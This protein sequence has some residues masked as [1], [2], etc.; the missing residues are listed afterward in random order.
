MDENNFTD[1]QGSG[2]RYQ[3]TSNPDQ[4]YTYGSYDANAQNGSFYAGTDPGRRPGKLPER[5][6]INTE[7]C[8]LRIHICK[9]NARRLAAAGR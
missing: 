7:L 8:G 4:Q 1:N 5:R 2:L 6:E 9:K 3:D